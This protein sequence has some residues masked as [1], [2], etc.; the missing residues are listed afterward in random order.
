MKKIENYNLKSLST[1]G[2]GP[3]STQMMIIENERDLDYISE[4]SKIIGNASNILFSHNSYNNTFIRLQGDF[5]QYTIIDKTNAIV[6]IGAGVNINNLIIELSKQN[7]GGLEFLYGIPAT[8]GGIIKN[9]AG[10]FGKNIFEFINTIYTN[11][12]IIHKKDFHYE[13]RKSNIDGIILYAELKLIK[14]DNSIINSAIEGYINNR[15][16]TQPYKEKSLGSVFK[17]PAKKIYA[18]QLIEE[19][20]YKGKCR[21]GICVSSKHA[22][23]I[24]NKDDGKANDFIEIAEEIKNNIYNNKSITLEYEIEFF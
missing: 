20:G 23:F 7:I 4:D 3:I 22:N 18:G 21:N 19:A 5:S 1:I 13:Y 16:S 9:N 24:V 10:A 17:N 12:G 6:K 11:K 14:K 8:I 15:R 2:I